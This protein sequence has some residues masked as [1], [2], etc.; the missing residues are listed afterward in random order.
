MPEQQL[1]DMVY[2]R[3]RA[4]VPPRTR[5]LRV[6]VCGAGMVGSWTAAALGRQCAHVTVADYDVVEMANVGVQSYTPANVGE[7]KAM[8][9]ANANAGLNVEAFC[10]SMEQLLSL[11][12]SE[13]EYNVVVSAIDSMAGRKWL[14]EWCRDN[15][16]ELFVDVRVMG[17]MV[18]VL[19]ARHSD[20]SYD[21]Y[22]STILPDSE[23]E[24]ATCGAE[25]TVYSGMFAA[26][27]VAA[28]VNNWA[29]G[30]KVATKEAWHT[31]LM[32]K[33]D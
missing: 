29:R 33:L 18:F 23:V 30:M 13:P 3:V 25:G 5:G 26:S 11:G 7:M 21:H 19:T 16:I 8:A 4:L 15:D 6:L 1:D 12:F 28:T 14:A 2:E 9:V 24:E 22:L 27:R 31:G 10:G 17:E 20:G 32:Q